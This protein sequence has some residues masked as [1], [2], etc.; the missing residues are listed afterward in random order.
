M[1]LWLHRLE[2]WIPSDFSL[3]DIIISSSGVAKGLLTGRLILIPQ[4]GGPSVSIVARCRLLAVSHLNTAVC[5][6]TPKAKSL[7]VGTHARTHTRANARVHIH[8]HTH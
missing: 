4:E 2:T 7:I 3:D 1:R 8:V 5:L 6:T